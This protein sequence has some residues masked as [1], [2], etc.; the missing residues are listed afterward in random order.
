MN[1]LIA[2]VSQILF[3]IVPPPAPPK[4]VPYDLTSPAWSLTLSPEL[5]EI[6]GIE[7]R[8]SLIACVQDEIGAIYYVHARTGAIV[9]KVQFGQPGDFEDLAFV[10]DTV[11]VLRSDGVLYAVPGNA[12]DS[13]IARPIYTGITAKNCEGLWHDAKNHRLLIAVRGKSGKGKKYTDLR[14]VFAYDLVSRRLSKEP[15]LQIDIPAARAFAL[16]K[17]ID[18][19]VK[20]RKKGK[21]AERELKFSTSAIAIH[22]ETG[23]YYLVSSKDRLLFVADSTG[24]FLAVQRLDPMRFLQPE[25][26]SFSKNGDLF[27]SNEGVHLQPT[28]Y[29]FALKRRG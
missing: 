1:M 16:E 25:G 13:V 7:V 9:R 14:E 18:L 4:D 12:R 21:I 28:I 5:H 17:G 23:H 27:I 24:R 10:N 29:G 20:Y 15:A 3:S 26:L 8:D 11:F 6:S 22:P 2:I 19:P